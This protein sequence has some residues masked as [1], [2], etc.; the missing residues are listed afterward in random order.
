MGIVH[1]DDA[2]SYPLSVGHINSTWTFLGEAAGS[3]DVGVRRLAVE[4]GSWSTPVHEHGRSEEIFFVLSGSGV[5][6]E[7]VSPNPLAPPAARVC[8]VRAGDCLVYRPGRGAHSLHAVDEPLVFLAFG[9]R[10]ADEAPQFPR[11]G[12][13]L[14]R[15]RLVE[16]AGTDQPLP[17]QFVREAE[18]GPPDVSAPGERPKTIVNLDDVEVETREE[19][20]VVR[21]RR[22]LGRAA[23]SVRTGLQHVEVAPGKESSYQ[24][25]HTR[26]EEIFVVLDG[27]GVLLLG[28]EEIPV[29][30]GS[31]VARPPG[32]GVAH[33]FRA[34]DNGLTLL[35]YGTRDPDDVVYYPR[36]NKIFFRG[37]GLVA[38]L[39]QVDY[40][41][42][43]E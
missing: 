25:V 15:G 19:T 7:L 1:W 37:V 36:S 18:L 21:K 8:E 16:T 2:P 20:R 26:E 24:H 22:D 40:S 30:A 6:Y 10:N 38:R 32:T 29:R 3:V 23:G 27:E 42:G 5:S 13:A 39:E 9:P 31:V 17:V 4:P 34:G 41:D 14:L 12:A 11:L 28:E 33:S 35:A 43:E